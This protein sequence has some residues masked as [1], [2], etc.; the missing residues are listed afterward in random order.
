MSLAQ[1]WWFANFPSQACCTVLRLHSIWL[2]M[3][4]LWEHKYDQ[5]ISK[6]FFSKFLSDLL[7]SLDVFGICAAPRPNFASFENSLRPASQCV[8][9][10]GCPEERCVLWAVTH[11]P[12]KSRYHPY[13]WRCNDV[14]MLWF[15]RFGRFQ[16]VL[17]RPVPEAFIHSG[18]S[19]LNYAA[20]C[21]AIVLT[22][23]HR[24]AEWQ[25]M[26]KL[27]SAEIMIRPQKAREIQVIIYSFLCDF[28]MWF[29]VSAPCKA[30]R[31]LAVFVLGGPVSSI[32]YSDL[33]DV[34]LRATI[35]QRVWSIRLH[36]PETERT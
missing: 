27:L 6:M 25:T 28:C 1:V 35:F 29:Q 33:P 14:T 32:E 9:F 5:I 36:T 13:H 15:I 2:H 16:H 4:K 3:L 10:D 21:E 22:R 12:V 19:V 8:V 20:V 24:R 11:G 26:A 18:E 23:W 7:N 34:D 31:H 17:T 30:L